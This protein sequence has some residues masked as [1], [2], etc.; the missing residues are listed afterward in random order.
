VLRRIVI[1][2]AMPGI[3]AGSIIVF[4]LSVGNFV[5]PVLLG[6]K[7]GLWFTE[8]IY[9]QFITRF[10]WPEGSAFGF[11]LLALSTAIVWVGLKLTGQSFGATLRRG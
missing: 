2:H 5:T 6:G 11:L 4:M 8:Q 1:P 10:N 9:A 3:L 7:N